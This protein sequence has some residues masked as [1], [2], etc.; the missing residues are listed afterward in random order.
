MKTSRL[1]DL[2]LSDDPASQRGSWK[3]SDKHRVQFKSEDKNEEALIEADILS[4]ETGALI[5][6]LR[7]RQSSQRV[8][9]R[10]YRLE[11]KWQADEQNRL[12]FA[13]DR[14][15]GVRDVLVFD[16]NWEIG[17]QNEIIYRYE[18]ERLKTKSKKTET[19]ALRGFWEVSADHRL[20]YA[21]EG[22]K[23]EILRFRG[24]FQTGSI[25]AKKGELRYQL[26][27]EY[28]AR[29]KGSQL[30][31]F[32]KWKLTRELAIDFEMEYTGGKRAALSFG[33]L[34]NFDSKN[35]MKALLTK[36]GESL[37]IEVVFTTKFEDPEGEAFVRLKNTIEESLVE[38]G[39]AFKW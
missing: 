24:S 38:G 1:N 20:V 39:F 3:L 15:K 25:R 28:G 26:G 17:K 13:V 35:Q 31:F 11:G 10:V 32:G 30:L 16:G 18:K 7:Q 21:L 12:L 19:F 34:Y 14:R 9:S 33:A 27:A 23:D 5:V 6:S 4:A 29:K 22:S 2:I 37:G 8:V 36:E